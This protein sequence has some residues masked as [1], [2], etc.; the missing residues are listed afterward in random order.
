M[1]RHER[2]SV[3][4]SV[5]SCFEFVHLSPACPDLVEPGACR[6]GPPNG[7]REGAVS[8][9]EPERRSFPA[10]PTRLPGA[11]GARA[12]RGPWRGLRPH[13]LRSPLEDFFLPFFAPLNFS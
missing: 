6:P 7:F 12:W 5:V 2:V 3:V 13:S 10:G 9:P 4:V 1:L 8:R 11:P